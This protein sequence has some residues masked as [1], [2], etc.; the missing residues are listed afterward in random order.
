MYGEPFNSPIK[1]EPIIDHAVNCLKDIDFETLVFRGF[2]GAVV[3]PAV[4][5]QLKKTWVLVR[6]PGDSAHSCRR[7]EGGVTGRYVVLDDFIDTGS[8]IRAIIEAVN[9]SSM[10]D[11]VCVGAFL[12]QPGWCE[13]VSLVDRDYWLER[14]NG[15][16]IL[17]WV[18]SKPKLEPKPKPKKAYAG[19]VSFNGTPFADLA[20][21][22]FN[23]TSFAD[24]AKTPILNDLTPV[25]EPAY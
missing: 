17:N 7:M 1:F 19:K 25:C 14:I 24:L 11:H 5:L 15:V 18:Y 8:T 6:K 2:S 9:E 21:V 10:C 13:K 22:S 23:D 16:K 20:K 12:Y 4:A 3:G